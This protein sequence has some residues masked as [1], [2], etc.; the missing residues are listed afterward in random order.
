MTQISRKTCTQC[1]EQNLAVDW[2]C[3]AC[4]AALVAPTA[5][6]SD[7]TTVL[8]G[9]L[10]GDRL[11]LLPAAHVRDMPTAMPVA[12]VGAGRS[13]LAAVGVAVLL[14]GVAI[15]WALSRSVSEPPIER[16][17]PTFAA[18]VVPGPAAFTPQPTA[19]VPLPPPVNHPP[20]IGSSSW[21]PMAGPFPARP[22]GVPGRGTPPSRFAGLPAG[23]VPPGWG[24]AAARPSPGLGMRHGGAGAAARPS[25]L[26]ASAAPPAADGADDQ[27]TIRIQNTAAVPIDLELNGPVP[28][29]ARIAPGEISFPLPPGSYRLTLT[30]GGHRK[31]EDVDLRAGRDHTVIFP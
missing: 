8:P 28:Q 24:A 29:N 16:S 20:G 3:W 18:P 5:A 21:P 23:G 14:L 6:P 27:P 10:G 19:P 4:G 13:V 1:G 26:S 11:S 22:Y 17:L 25:G 9:A 30:G 2:R 12:P 31:H 7:A 15:G